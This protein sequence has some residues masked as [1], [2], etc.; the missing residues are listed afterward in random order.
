[1]FTLIRELHRFRAFPPAADR[2]FWSRIA[3]APRTAGLAAALK[4]IADE[5]KG[6]PV[7][8]L[9]AALFMEF[10]RTGER[11]NY[12]LPYFARRRTLEAL[13][14]TEILEH[15]GEYLDTIVE[16]LW[17][18]LAEYT[19]EVPAHVFRN[20]PTAIF[21]HLPSESFPPD[22]PLPPPH[23]P[24]VGLFAAETAGYLAFTVALLDAEL[25]AIS[26]NLLRA[27]REEID[28]RVLGP[29]E[30][31]L[32]GFNWSFGRNNWAPWCSSNLLWVANEIMSDDDRFTVFVRRL[33]TVVDRYLERYAADGC[34]DE[35][36][37]YWQL[38][39]GRC[40]LYAE[41]LRRASGGEVD[42]FA[43]P[44]FREMCNYI[45]YAWYAGC[46]FASFADFGGRHQVYTGL[47]RMLARRSGALQSLRMAHDYEAESGLRPQVHTGLIATLLELAEAPAS[48]A[49]I[50]AAPREFLH[51]YPESQQLHVKCGG[52]YVA[53]KGGHN[54]ESHNHLDV[55]QFVFGA[56]GRLA[57]A[58]LGTGTYTRETFSARRYENWVQNSIGHNP[59]LFDGVGQSPGRE[60]HAGSFT[61]E[62]TPG[63]FTAVCDLTPAYPAELGLLHCE[64]RLRFDG[65]RVT[66][67]D[68]WR[69]KKPVAW[70]VR[71][72]H[73]TGSGVRVSCAGASVATGKLA[74]DD[75]WLRSLWG[76]A[77]GETKISAPAS[78]EGEVTCTIEA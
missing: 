43:D 22:D 7:P 13:V 21:D 36:P 55:G 40:A 75:E 50:A 30:R 10:R 48:E 34:C 4:K 24:F 5:A 1:M 9:P 27:V 39:P 25:R 53:M 76:D 59:P 63:D 57:V 41:G 3:A 49:E 73:E 66:V 23:L 78:A 37:G 77:V 38:S 11:I 16:Y 32:D 15:R 31:Y 65:K 6:K 72:F 52:L 29:V 64:R 56:G 69:A 19:W 67:T 51:L 35:G 45:G 44:K 20:R 28:L 62:G 17:S 2:E 71:L 18:I 12:E 42:L 33:Q 61:V 58:D 60:F 54:G 74:F 46:R 68:S 14:V 70:S 8:E 26:P 47:I